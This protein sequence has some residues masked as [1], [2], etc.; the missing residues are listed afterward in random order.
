MKKSV[1]TTPEIQRV[2]LDRQISLQLNSELSP[3]EEPTDWVNLP[4]TNPGDHP[5]LT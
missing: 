2:E 1:Y 5:V 3:E 4:D